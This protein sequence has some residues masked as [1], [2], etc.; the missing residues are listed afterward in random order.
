VDQNAIR[1][2]QEL[3]NKS[4][5]EK[6]MPLLLKLLVGHNVVSP[7]KADD[8]TNSTGDVMKLADC[9]KLVFPK[10]NETKFAEHSD[11]KTGAF[12]Y[13]PKAAKEL[14]NFVDFGALLKHDT[15]VGFLLHENYS[16]DELEAKLWKALIKNVG[17]IGR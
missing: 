10:W 15:T 9:I 17:F 14:V 4:I 2:L 7:T 8:L 16:Y 12:P 6:E 13:W 1:K 11:R 5:F 3:T